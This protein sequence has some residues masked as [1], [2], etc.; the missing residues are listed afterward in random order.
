MDAAVVEAEPWATVHDAAVER[1]L[2]G[3]AYHQHS[4]WCRIIRV[5]LSEE[6]Y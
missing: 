2:G 1:M 5:I 3:E 6:Y 4:Y